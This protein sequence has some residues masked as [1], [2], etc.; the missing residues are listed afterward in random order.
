MADPLSRL[1]RLPTVLAED[2]EALHPFTRLMRWVALAIPANTGFRLRTALVRAAGWNVHRSTIFSRVPFW[3][4]SGPIRTRLT[5]GADCY[6]NVGCHFELNDHI[7]IG[8]GVSIGHDVLILTSSHRIGPSEHRAGDATTAPVTIGSGA[9]IGA[10]S[11]LLPGVSVGEGAIVS[12]GSVVNTDVA[13]DS[14]VA[15]VP[16]TVAVRRLAGGRRKSAK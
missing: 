3:S 10:R 5:V 15:G 16:A 11:V 8:D 1:R 7:T 13:A 6:V 14:V 4:G 2:F 9:W 12:A